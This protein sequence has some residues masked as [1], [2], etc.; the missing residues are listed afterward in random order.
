MTTLLL[1]PANKSRGGGHWRDD[2]YD[3]RN[4]DGR[5]IGRIMKH[6]QAKAEEPWLWT[7]IE[8]R[9]RPSTADHGYAATR[10]Q[11]M[12]DFKV[13]WGRND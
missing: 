7:I 6:P 9:A 10:G 1:V 13:R 4:G 5:V 11:A 2:D 3:V 8:R 12:A